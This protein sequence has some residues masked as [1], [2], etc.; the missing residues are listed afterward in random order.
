MTQLWAYDFKSGDLFYNIISDK[1]PYAVEVTYQDLYGNYKL[2][3]VD[4]PSTVKNNGKTY[5]VSNIG[6]HAFSNCSQLKNVTIPNSVTVIKEYGFFFCS[7]LSSVNVPNSVT[8]I[9]NFAFQGCSGLTSI[10]LPNSLNSLGINVFA[11]CDNVNTK[12]DGNANY[13]GN[14]DNPY[15]V[16]YKAKD[17]NI[18]NCVI[19]GN[20]KFINDGAFQNCTN[21]TSINIPNSVKC[22]GDWTFSGCE[23]LKDVILPNSITTIGIMAFM[24]CISIET[25]NIPKSVTSIGESAFSGCSGLLS[26]VIPDGVA[27]IGKEAFEG[28][29]NLTEVTIPTATTSID[30][31]AFASCGNARI[32]C[33]M[34]SQPAGWNAQWNPDG[35][36][37]EWLGVGI[38]DN[39][40]EH[41]NIYVHNH[42]I[43]IE[44]TTDYVWVFDAVGRF[45]YRNK[46]NTEVSVKTPGLYIVKVGQYAE[47]VVVD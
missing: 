44:N 23:N 5:A 19:N 24:G 12:N 8:T 16:L 40:E 7:G 33:K 37:V 30:E 15:L 21:L 36:A 14:N 29:Y 3:K 31:F 11:M 42:T 17:M 1:E 32:F 6:E 38:D 43:T 46:G 34:N 13:I 47:Q 9:E 35:L 39:R 28:C 26:V 45:V 10:T 20:C 27:N 22:I 41:I 2:T 18:E 4:I 25:I